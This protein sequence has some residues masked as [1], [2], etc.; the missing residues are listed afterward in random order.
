M[1][2]VLG[3][4]PRDGGTKNRYLTAWLHPITYARRRTRTGTPARVTDFKS[5]AS[6]IP[7]G[8]RSITIPACAGGVKLN[9]CLSDVS[10][11]SEGD[12]D[13]EGHT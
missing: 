1:A 12:N 11:Y 4:E 9:T 2:G 6:T 5:G 13:N 8:G 3:F 7:P 10:R